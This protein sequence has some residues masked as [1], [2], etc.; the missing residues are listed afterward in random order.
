VFA[1]G[2]THIREDN[3]ELRRALSGLRLP[4]L[5]NPGDDENGDRDSDSPTGTHVEHR[6]DDRRENDE[7]D[8]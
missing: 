3:A 7:G 4:R 6:A 2:G 1:T 8:D 5:N